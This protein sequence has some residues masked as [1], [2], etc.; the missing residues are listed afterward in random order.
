MLLKHK[1]GAVSVVE[2]TYDSKRI[3]DPFPATL[4]EIEGMK[5]SIILSH[6]DNMTVT[7]DGKVKTLNIALNCYHG[8][9]GHG[10]VL[11]RLIKYQHIFCRLSEIIN[12]Q[13]LLGEII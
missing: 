12:L 1:S 8:L 11:K 3:P 13:I 4:L 2:T 10:M 6:E 5:G 9:A 7:S